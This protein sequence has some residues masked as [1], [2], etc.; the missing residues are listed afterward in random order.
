MLA[1]SYHTQST[2]N[3]TVLQFSDAF[4]LDYDDEDPIRRLYQWN[5]RII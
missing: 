4:L 1:R 3:N 5:I 2:I